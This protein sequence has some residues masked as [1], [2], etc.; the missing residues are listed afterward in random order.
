M[1]SGV[2]YAILRPAVLFGREDVLINNIAWFLRRFPLFGVFGDGRY[3]IQPIYVGDMA[4]LAIEQGQTREN[5][6]IDA[7]GPEK[8]AFRELVRVIGETIGKQRPV[9]SIPPFIGFLIS[10]VIGRLVGD[11]VLTREE[12][13]GLMAGTLA[14]YS[15]PTGKTKLTEWLREHAD[16]VGRRYTNELKRRKDRKGKYASN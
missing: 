12:I 1:R 13:E 2:S 6:I 16:T 8:F 5:R 3:E 11:V 4:K 9:I 10:R 14:T 15:P 7:V